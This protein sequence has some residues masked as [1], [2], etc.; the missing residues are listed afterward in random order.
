M[1]EVFY[2]K[3][4]QANVGNISHIHLPRKICQHYEQSRTELFDLIRNN[5][6]D[7]IKPEEFDDL[8][9]EG[10]IDNNDDVIQVKL[11]GLAYLIHTCNSRCLVPDKYGKLIFRATNDCKSEENTEHVLIYLPKHLSKPCIERLEKSV[12]TTK[13]LKKSKTIVSFKSNLDYF[14]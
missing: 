4:Y 8:I 14:H 11:D 5:V 9:K 12:L 3:E 2:R 10:V 6:V 1:L 7:I 13:I